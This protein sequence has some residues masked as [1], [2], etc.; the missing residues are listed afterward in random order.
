MSAGAKKAKKDSEDQ[1]LFASKS[2]SQLSEL[3]DE[4]SFLH[5]EYIL[6]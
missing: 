2:M 5:Y 3:I 6:I 4:V 1:L